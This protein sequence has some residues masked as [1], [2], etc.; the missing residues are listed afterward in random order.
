MTLRIVL[1]TATAAGVLV[2]SAGAGLAAG[3]NEAYTKQAGDGNKLTI[4]QNY[5]AGSNRVGTTLVPILQQGDNNQFTETQLTGGGTSGLDHNVIDAGSQLG[6]GNKFT[7]SYGQNG[8]GHNTISTMLQDGDNN[9]AKVGRNG[10][11]NSLVTLLKQDGSGNYLTIT[12]AGS[13]NIVTEAVQLGD[14]NGFSAVESRRG[15]GTYLSQSGTGNTIAQS[16]IEGSNNK[17]DYN[18][19]NPRAASVHDIT[20]VGTGNGTTASIAKTLGS[21]GNGIRVYQ[22]G[23]SNDFNLQQGVNTASTQ[24]FIVLTQTGDDNTATA[25]QNGSYNRLNAVQSG[26]LN[27][28]VANV[29][30]DNNGSGSFGNA[31]A[32]ALAVSYALSSGDVFQTGDLHDVELTING[33]SNQFAFDQFGGDDN[34]ITATMGGN[35]NQAV[36]VQNGSGNTVTVSQA[37]GSNVATSLQVGAGNTNSISQ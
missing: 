14:N 13:G 20:Q 6:D 32:S 2:A 25:T 3:T 15:W 7:S 5:G 34:T 16:Y 36:A 19:A 21:N 12:Q 28:V 9:N 1:A 23:S 18:A 29:T 17:T 11:S 8:A 33:A 4:V 37:G 26:D 22:N 27:T 24:N 35:S 31:G 30:G 10:G